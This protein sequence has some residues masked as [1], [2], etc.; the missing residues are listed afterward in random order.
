MKIQKFNKNKTYSVDQII[1]ISEIRNEIQKLKDKFNSEISELKE[2]LIDF[3]VFEPELLEDPETVLD[4]S[5]AK[6]WSIRKIDKTNKYYDNVPKDKIIE[7]IFWPN[8]DEGYDDESLASDW[9]SREDIENFIEF[10]K[11]RDAYKAAKKYNL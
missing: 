5:E 3:L 7:V 1:K 4:E 6:F 9:F 2:P 11:N 8:C 10:M